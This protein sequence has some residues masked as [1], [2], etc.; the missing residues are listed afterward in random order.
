MTGF[1]GNFVQFMFPRRPDVG[2]EGSQI[3]LQSNLFRIILKDCFVFHYEVFIIPDGNIKR[4]N[5]FVLY[6]KFST[7]QIISRNIKQ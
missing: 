6:Y 3:S 7:F 1:T 5:R 2:S 4:V